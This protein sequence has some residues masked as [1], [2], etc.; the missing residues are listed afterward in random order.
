[1]GDCEQIPLHTLSQ[2]FK[3]NVFKTKVKKAF[4]KRTE[5]GLSCGK[6]KFDPGWT[7]TSQC[8][9]RFWKTGIYLRLSS[10]WL[11]SSLLRI[12]CKAWQTWQDWNTDRADRADFYGF[13]KDPPQSAASAKSVFP[14]CQ[15]CYIILGWKK[16]TLPT[17]FTLSFFL[18]LRWKNNFAN[19]DFE[20]PVLEGFF[21]NKI[22]ILFFLRS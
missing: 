14:S 21:K 4:L 20:T 13:L 17:L 5:R 11:K 12:G 10:F 2:C 22:V 7:E 15:K 18:K 8:T 6:G 3:K 9:K 19:F 1:M 16:I